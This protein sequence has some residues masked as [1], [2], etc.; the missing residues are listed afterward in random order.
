MKSKYLVKNHS[1]KPIRLIKKKKNA[2]EMKL[3]KNKNC[4]PSEN[5]NIS[6]SVSS[7]LTLAYHLNTQS[8]ESFRL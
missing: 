1:T 3:S 5:F 4:T 8:C 2:V 7:I 6:S